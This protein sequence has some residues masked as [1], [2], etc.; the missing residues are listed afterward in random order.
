MK[1]YLNMAGEL[2]H[3]LF[4]KHLYIRYTHKNTNILI[5]LLFII[6]THKQTSNK[7]LER[8]FF[9]IY[10][11]LLF[12]SLVPSNPKVI[13]CLTIDDPFEILFV[14]IF[15]VPQINLSIVDPSLKKI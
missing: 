11:L 7:Y 6:I 9:H 1:R 2:D 13:T 5:I 15:L 8:V 4:H 12:Q 10:F 3:V 14:F